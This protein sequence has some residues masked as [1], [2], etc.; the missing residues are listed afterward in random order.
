M[1]ET[2]I[3]LAVIRKEEESTGMLMELEQALKLKMKI[4]LFIKKDLKHNAFRRNA[5]EVFEFSDESEL[6]NQLVEF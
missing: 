6:L 3:L 4:V 1:S 2:D 5:D